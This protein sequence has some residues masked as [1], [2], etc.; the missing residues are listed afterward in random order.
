MFLGERAELSVWM[1][2]KVSMWGLAEGIELVLH[3][4]PGVVQK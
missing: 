1:T 4:R 2:G 3:C